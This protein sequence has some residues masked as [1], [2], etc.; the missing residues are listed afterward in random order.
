MLSILSYYIVSR[1]V[2]CLSSTIVEYDSKIVEWDGWLPANLF[3]PEDKIWCRYPVSQT[4][5]ISPPNLVNASA[6]TDKFAAIV[7]KNFLDLS[8]IICH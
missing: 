3:F 6:V 4:D 5:E 1:L 8:C 7:R 2:K